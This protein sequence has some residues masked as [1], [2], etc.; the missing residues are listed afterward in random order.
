MLNAEN[1]LIDSKATPLYDW[2]TTL[3]SED[4]MYVYRVEN[5]KVTGARSTVFSDGTTLQDF[6]NIV[7]NLGLESCDKISKEDCYVVR[8]NI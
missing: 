3:Y 7:F 4:R 8:E 5:G 2:S 6:A 1:S